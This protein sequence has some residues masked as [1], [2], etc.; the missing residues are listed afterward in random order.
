MSTSKG[1][2]NW[3]ALK[4]KLVAAPA[5]AQSDNQMRK[6]K[7]R[8]GEELK[9]A[10]A[11]LH[12]A[13]EAEQQS[14]V[15]ESHVKRQKMESKVKT[16]HGHI[17]E[18]MKAKY[19]ALDCEMVGTGFNGKQS[20]LARCCMVNFDGEVIYDKFVKP[21]GFVTDFRTDWSGVRS[22]DLFGKHAKNAVSFAE[23]QEMVAAELKNKI[24]VGHGLKNDLT[25]LGLSHS[26]SMT[27]DTAC[28][29]PYMR[30][31]RNQKYRPRALRELSKDFLG[32][33]IQT[34]EHDPGEDARAA[35]MLYR[36]KMNEWEASLAE[37][38]FGKDPPAGAA[39]KKKQ[40]D[41]VSSEEAE[42][43]AAPA[44]AAAAPKAKPRTSMFGTSDAGLRSVSDV[45]KDKK[46]WLREGGA[47]GPKKKKKP[48]RDEEK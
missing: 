22:Q 37:K 27:R 5:V 39:A 9:E 43:T 29:R 11:K 23:C 33:T 21:Q 8:R 28:Y 41:G 13:K 12:E 14:D 34:G 17:S 48:R 18:K 32:V 7:R 40:E 3:L 20:L 10:V 35:L 6:K 4:S 19:V 2:S 44:P 47:D 24:L 16:A 36:L 31:H 26:R 42:A 46:K 1:S 30:P 15:S 45:D 25:V 38:R